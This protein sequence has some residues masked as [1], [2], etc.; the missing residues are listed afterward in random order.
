MRLGRRT[1]E[2]VLKPPVVEWLNAG[3]AALLARGGAQVIDVRMPTE[4]AQ[5][6]IK[7]SIN[8]P[9]FRLREDVVQ[10]FPRTSKL[11]VYCNTGERS[12]AAA[13]ILTRLGYG[14]V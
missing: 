14:E 11:V 5:R 4:H 8:V 13:F 9:L 7:G 1:F 3:Q 2:E 10:R 6:A 12:A